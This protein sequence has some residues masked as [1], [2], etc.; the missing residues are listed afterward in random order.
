MKSLLYSKSKANA[1]VSVPED[2]S[3]SNL[4]LENPIKFIFRYL[5]ENTIS[6]AMKMNPSIEKLLEEYNLSKKYNLNNVSNCIVSH[7]VPTS[8]YAEQLFVK[9]GYNKNSNDYKILIQSALLHDIGKVFIPTDILE[10]NAKL[11]HKERLIIELHNKFS[12]EIL[13]TTDLDMDVAKLSYEHHNYER[14]LIRNYKNQILTISDIYSALK[15]NRPY[16]R[17]MDDWQAKTV[18]FDMGVK[19]YFDIGYLKYLFD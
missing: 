13:K 17:A 19:G 9:M 18:M 16:R 5:N 6:K 4:A 14:K 2:F 7:L 1:F 11:N 8:R 3:G 10:K 15:E 12:Y